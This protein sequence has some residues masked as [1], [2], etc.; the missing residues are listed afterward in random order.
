MTVRDAKQALDGARRGT[1]DYSSKLLAY[2][3]A[4]RG[5]QGAQQSWISQ[6]KQMRQAALGQVDSARRQ[7]D[8]FLKA[9]AGMKLNGAQQQAL[10]AFQQNYSN[11]L[12]RQA[13]S[14]LNL[15]RARRGQ[16]A[17]IGAQEAALGKLARTA[18]GANI[19]R[20][21]S[22]RFEAP[23]DVGNVAAAASR[24]LQAGV[25]PASVKVAASTGSAV[26]DIRALNAL[27]L[28]E[29]RLRV[30]ESGVAGVIGRLGTV[31]GL[32]LPT[33]TQRVVAA[34]IGATLAGIQTVVAKRVPPKTATVTA[35]VGQA[36][37]GISSVISLMAGIQSVTRTITILTKHVGKAQG[38]IN[39]AT[40]GPTPDKIT[41]ASARANQV[42]VARA[43]GKFSRPTFLVGEEDKPE[44]VIATN[45]AYRADNLRYLGMAADALGVQMA[46]RGYDGSRGGNPNQLIGKVPAKYFYAGVDVAGVQTLTDNLGQRTRT[47]KH[48]KGSA[49]YQRMVHNLHQ[50]KI[51][52]GRI[53]GLNIDQE[54]NRQLMENDAHRGPRGD[55]RSWKKHLLKR[56]GAI[57]SLIGHLRKAI[58]FAPPGIY[59]KQ[60]ESQLAVARGVQG[61]MAGTQFQEAGTAPQSLDDF[62]KRDVRLS[63]ALPGLKLALAKAGSTETPDD[64]IAAHKALAD[65][66]RDQVI[67]SIHNTGNDTELLT[68]AYDALSQ[69]LPSGSG[70]AGAGSADLQ[71][72]LDQANSNLAIARGEAA[73]NAAYA[74]V[75]GGP[76][77][78]GTGVYH[79]ARA[80]AEAGP[81]IQFNIQTLHPGD[82][83]TLRAIGDA[84]ASG[85]GYQGAR[86]N[87]RL[88]TG[89]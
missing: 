56:G 73:T 6:S 87:P 89:L 58:K 24:A 51:A 37:S 61:D 13:A 9:T 32:K 86:R 64:D 54:T 17:V 78:I 69:E 72:Q 83:G 82:P 15:G 41:A 29:K 19:A 49:Q 47:K 84:A 35:N 18:G 68:E 62:I 59:T 3:D 28:R 23:K 30:T 55:F 36:L 38:G 25:R 85:F 67:P 76:G 10:A 27:V 57:T 22:T 16:V 26:A 34:G 63:G 14:E 88:K 46:A 74:M 12:D 71:A 66:Y 7:L 2:R 60:L 1:A 48:P 77:D 11:Q 45:P 31:V 75:A 4:L 70:G 80:A 53:E 5:Q 40:G 20:T 43:Q 50:L 33:K 42:P 21:I 44:F 8:G 39:F 81:S 79:S 52:Q 65:F